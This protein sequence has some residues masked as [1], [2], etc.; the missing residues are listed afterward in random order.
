MREFVY[1]RAADVA[2]AVASVT[3]RPD[4]VFLGGG[5]NLVDHMKLG[6]SRPG[7]LVDVS[8]LPLKSVEEQADG[9]VRVGAGVCNSELAADP[10]IRDRYPML[11]RALLAGASPQLRNLATVG[12]NLLQRTRC[13]SR[14]VSISRTSRRRATSVSRDPDV[15]PLRVTRD[16]TRCSA[17]QSTVWQ[18]IPRIWLWH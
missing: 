14:V 16:I 1:E 13:V 2:S 15:R 8:R 5:T 3:A 6:V 17:R 18:H 10:L 4:A 11:S 9:R 12:G 7:L